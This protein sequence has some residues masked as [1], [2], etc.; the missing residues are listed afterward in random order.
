M[1]AARGVL[2]TWSFSAGV[3]A[4]PSCTLCAS[5]A[6]C[7]YG[8]GKTTHLEDF[9][10]VSIGDVLVFNTH[11]LLVHKELAELFGENLASFSGGLQTWYIL[12]PP[13]FT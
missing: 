2:M 10:L 5:S 7:H 11:N 3:S 12:E 4:I 6:A 1:N 9:T 8:K 13:L